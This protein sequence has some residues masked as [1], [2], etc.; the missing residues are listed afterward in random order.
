[1]TL[2]VVGV[3][4]LVLAVLP[5]AVDRWAI[6]RASPAALVA[7]ALAALGGL[8]LLPLALAI[9]LGLL[10]THAGSGVRPLPLA[11]AGL[12]GVVTGGRAVLAWVRIRRTW[13]TIGAAVASGRLS[14]SGP[15]AVVPLAE[16]T[17][18]VAGSTVVVSSALLDSLT[19]EQ[20]DAVLAHEHAH[21]EGGHPRLALVA[22]A[23]R[24]GVFGIPPAR[25]AETRLRH[26]LEVLADAEAARRLGDPAPVTAALATVGTG[27]DEPALLG[28][29]DEA[30]AD[31]IDRLASTDQ[32]SRRSDG[33]VVVAAALAGAGSLVAL[34]SAF[35]LRL[36]WLG[37]LACAAAVAAYGATIRPLVAAGSRRS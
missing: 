26:E 27:A 16:P 8:M 9:C 32:P 28:F 25:R 33:I 23:L 13:R 17:A 1:M 15:V 6:R 30:V 21:L 4:A 19:D 2:A 12:V 24:R 20:T 37:V 10:G 14:P 34:C 5:A 18:F 7:L 29:A 3:A 11:G 22:H 36:I 35:H 31:R